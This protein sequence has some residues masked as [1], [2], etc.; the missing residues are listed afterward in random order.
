MLFDNH[1][2]PKQRL[3]I[4][5]PALVCVL[6]LALAAVIVAN[7][8]RPEPTEPDAPV[9]PEISVVE[10]HNAQ[11]RPLVATTGRVNQDMLDRDSSLTPEALAT[12]ED[13]ARPLYDEAVASCALS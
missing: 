12:I 11:A 10:V 2:R 13:K 9:I 1:G 8:P 5:I 6:T 7:R 4:W 3:P